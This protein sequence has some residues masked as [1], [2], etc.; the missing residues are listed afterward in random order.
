MLYVDAETMR[1]RHTNADVYPYISVTSAAK[2]DIPKRISTEH[3]T[4]NLI[5]SHR[6][7]KKTEF[8]FHIP[9]AM[10]VDLEHIC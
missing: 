3:D 4:H 2:H 9:A 7:K 6:S 1:P 8:A 5:H 10:E